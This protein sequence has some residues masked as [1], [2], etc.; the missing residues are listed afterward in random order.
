MTQRLPSDLEA[1]VERD[2]AAYHGVPGLVERDLPVGVAW[3][4]LLAEGRPL[5]IEEFTK[6]LG[7]SGEE[8]REALAPH[9]VMANFLG[10]ILLD[11]EGRV[12]VHDETAGRLPDYRIQWLDDGQVGMIPGCSEDAL[13]AVYVTERPARVGLP[14]P[15]TGEQIDLEFGADGVLRS[16]DPRGAVA[17]MRRL[18]LDW[19]P[20]DL[21]R[22]D[23]GDGL[24]FSSAEAALEWLVAHPRA[25][26]VPAEF[27]A[28][29]CLR[30]F[31]ALIGRSGIGIGSDPSGVG[32]KSPD[33]TQRR[34]E[35]YR[36]FDMGEQNGTCS[37]PL[38]EVGNTTPE[39]ARIQILRVPDCPSID[40]VRT[41]LQK[42]LAQLNVPAQVEELVGDYPSPTLLVNGRDVTGRPLGG[43]SA[44][45]LDLPTEAQVIAALR[46]G[47]GC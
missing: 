28:R 5:T 40:Q 6:V 37:R 13:W 44:C 21:K 4:R 17:T 10:E 20:R 23:C 27:F 32:I 26:I 14:C 45:R 42:V 1:I 11:A 34:A 16:L 31:Q 12:D 9:G 2:V 7:W 25:R 30:L 47:S 46:R 15:A 24:L 29:Y 19:S 38:G 36:G 8:V 22:G 35:R 18:D 43:T 33:S 39:V 41:T 3:L